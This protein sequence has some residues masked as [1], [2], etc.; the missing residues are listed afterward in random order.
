MATMVS[1]VVTVDGHTQVDGR[2]YVTET[3]TDSNGAVY[4][5]EYL[6]AVGADTAAIAAARADQII[7]DQTQAE[8]DA[9]LNG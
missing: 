1:S 6:S 4:V 9:V 2:R 8:L 7:A 3:H 5:I